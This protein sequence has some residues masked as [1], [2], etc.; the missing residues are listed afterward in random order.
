MK[1]QDIKLDSDGDLLIKD[2]DFVIGPSDEQH[3][4]DILNSV[5]GWFKEFPLVGINPFQFLNSRDS[6]QQ[7]NQIIKTQ[8]IGDGFA[9]ESVIVYVTINQDN[10]IE[11]VI[12]AIRPDVA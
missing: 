7:L 11:G 2:G 5:P 3:I 6:S 10:K 9:K 12:T 8:L 1:A 4:K